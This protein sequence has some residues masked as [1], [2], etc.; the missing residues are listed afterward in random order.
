M[1]SKLR[2]RLNGGLVATVR[3]G[4]PALLLWMLWKIEELSQRVNE[5]EILIRRFLA[6]GN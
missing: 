6:G 4:T 1:T 2:T 3:T 5:L